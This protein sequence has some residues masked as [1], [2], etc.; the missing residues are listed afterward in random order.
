MRE[1][2]FH[3]PA[4]LN[5]G[6]DAQSFVDACTKAIIEEFGGCTVSE[7]T[8]YW[9]DNGKLYQEPVYRFTVGIMDGGY[10][11]NR[12]LDMAKHFAQ[13]MDQLAVYYVWTDGEVSI[14]DLPGR[15]ERKA[16]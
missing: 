4:I 10:Q 1:A 7:A 2:H 8:G 11:E 15:E 5:D 9:M 16:A 13:L 12:L 14:I 6:S 3:L